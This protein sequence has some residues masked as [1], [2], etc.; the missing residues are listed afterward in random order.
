MKHIWEKSTGYLWFKGYVNLCTRMSYER[1]KV[2]GRDKVPSDAAVIFAPNH[3]N[4]LM[5]ALVVLL[6][7]GCPTTFVARFDVFRKPK[8][9][10][11]LFKLKM[12]PIARER[13]G[14]EALKG[15]A[16]IFDEMVDSM[17][18]GVPC[19]IFPEGT[20]RAKRSLLPLH[21]GICR[22]AQLAVEKLDK[23]VYI[24][25][26]GLDYESYLDYM[27]D[28]TVRYGDPIPIEDDFDKIE[29]LGILKER[30]SKLI[31]YFPDDENYAE[32]EARWEESRK[33]PLRW[34]EIPLGILALPL[35]IACGAV[36]LPVIGV[37]AYL[38]GKA[39]DKVW[40]NT[41]RFA[42][43]LLF[44]PIVWAP[45]SLFYLILKLYKHITKSI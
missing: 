39:K 45:H 43:R 29:M 10:N 19:C 11:L 31:T 26:V 42:S 12:L 21:K 41:F 28:V 22:V 17:G 13:D 5:D 40:S 7:N 38:I 4:T 6:A 23:P 37:S 1:F 14:M 20:H 24:V 27:G 35:F 2:E 32:A 25:P 9:R 44:T 3:C 34:W 16:E 30:L 18:H 36:C 15:N 8:V 33:K